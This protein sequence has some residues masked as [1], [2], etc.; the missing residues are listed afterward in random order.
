MIRTFAI[1]AAVSFAP[2]LSAQLLLGCHVSGAVDVLDPAN[3]DH[4][5]ASVAQSRI[6]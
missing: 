6:K 1:C 5:A 3:G 4:V 2:C